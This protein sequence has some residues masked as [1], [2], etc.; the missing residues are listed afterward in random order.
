MPEILARSKH[1]SL[2]FPF[3][4]DKEKKH[5]IT[6]TLG[7]SVIKL[8]FYVIKGRQNKLECLYLASFNGSLMSR[9]IILTLIV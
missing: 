4:S 9:Q 6:F 5:F 2:F 3:V 8:S 7:N 1:S